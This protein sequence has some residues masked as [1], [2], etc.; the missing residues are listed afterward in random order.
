[1]L[2]KE[3]KKEGMYDKLATISDVFNK[4]VENCQIYT[5]INKFFTIDEMLNPFRES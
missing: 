3:R 5:P 2:E 1:M 4:T